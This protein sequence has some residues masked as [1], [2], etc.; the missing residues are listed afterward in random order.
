MSLVT[1]KAEFYPVEADE[2]QIED[3]IDHSLTKW[4]GLRQANLEK[5]GIKAG[6]YDGIGDGNDRMYVGGDACALCSH[7][8]DEDWCDDD[9]EEGDGC[10]GCPLKLVRDGVP[11]DRTRDD[12]DKAPWNAWNEGHDPEPMILWLTKAKAEF[13]PNT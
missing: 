12:E 10:A 6:R 8:Y 4:I 1:W 5:H 9:E 2:V 7:H 3:S 13:S 11:C